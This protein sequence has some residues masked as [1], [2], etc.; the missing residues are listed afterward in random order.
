MLTL[1]LTLTLTLPLTLTLRL[2]LTLTLT[3]TSVGAA[4]RRVA[5]CPVVGGGVGGKVVGERVGAAGKRVPARAVLEVGGAIV[6]KGRVRIRVI[7]LALALAL[8]LR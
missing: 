8:T 3:L 4:E 6:V 5:A 1:T 2:S 7:S